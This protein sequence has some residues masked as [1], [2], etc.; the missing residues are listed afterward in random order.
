MGVVIEARALAKTFRVGFFLRKVTA[1]R[2]A[3]FE[4]QAGEIF[5]LV[6]PNGA[7]KTT[8]I[9]ILTGLIRASSGEARLLG[10]PVGSAEARRELGYLPDSPYFYE[11]LSVQELL[12]FHGALQGMT[13]ADRAKRADELIELVGLSHALDR[14]IR[15]FSKG[16]LQRAGLAQALMH[17]PK[18]VIL[19]EPQTG[20]DPLGRAEV[21][22][23]ILELKKQGTAVFFSSHIL[24]DVERVCDRVAVMVQG[25]VTGIGRLNELLSAR[26]TEVEIGLDGLKPEDRAW[27]E[28]KGLRWRGPADGQGPTTLLADDP[29]VAREALQEAL[30]RGASL[31]GYVERHE[32]LEDLFLREVQ[33]SAA[34]HTLSRE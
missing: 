24:P 34:S 1:L 33:Q 31:H 23:I 28:A 29:A 5:G 19:D 6:G 22:R 13:R 17:R 27:A 2:E 12:D 9:K 3:T 11:Y 8:T 21:T 32:N 25:R 30:R 15:K 10:K 20:L 14:P 7:G 4:V 18:L 16:M 26:V